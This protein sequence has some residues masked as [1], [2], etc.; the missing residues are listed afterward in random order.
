MLH[1]KVDKVF[2]IKELKLKKGSNMLTDEGY[3]D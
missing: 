1:N 2:F 3:C